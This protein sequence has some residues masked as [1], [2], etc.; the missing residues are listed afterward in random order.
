MSATATGSRPADVRPE[1]AD[2][3]VQTFEPVRFEPVPYAMELPVLLPQ[4]KNG[5][6]LSV[7]SKTAMDDIWCPF[8]FQQRRLLKNYG[9]S[10]VE[11]LAGSAGEAG[12]EAM[13]EANL[14]R[15]QPITIADAFDAV[16]DCWVR[17]LQSEYVDFRDERPSV[18]RDQVKRCVRHYLTEVVPTFVRDG[19]QLVALQHSFHE[20]LA[21][22]L[23]WT[24]NGVI[25]QVWFHPKKGLYRFR[26][27]KFRGNDMKPYRARRDR[28]GLLY[29]S[30]AE[31]AV[32]PFEEFYY[33]S[34][35]RKTGT[36]KVLPVRASRAAIVETWATV[37]SAVVQI[38]AL[39]DRLGLRQ[40]WPLTLD[41]ENWRCSERFCSA[42]GACPRGQLS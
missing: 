36:L 6:H 37:Q 5:R 7:L 14:L 31:R 32:L 24:V 25:D 27:T 29:V 11:L 21:P 10:S 22:H 35:N 4:D 40:P 41:P 2:D 1:L 33:D 12:V 19:W 13:L 18:V 23:L 28:Q 42:W 34:Y 16:D 15:G 30:G 8:R 20:R 17:R 39:N 26:D 3:F 9:H 38:A